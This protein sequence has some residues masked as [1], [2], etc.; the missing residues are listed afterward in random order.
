MLW[1]H[2]LPALGLSVYQRRYCF[3]FQYGLP[4]EMYDFCA[5]DVCNE[6]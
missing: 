6:E 1:H 3:S 5:S 4:V 2:L